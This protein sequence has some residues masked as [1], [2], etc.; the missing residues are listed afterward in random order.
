MSEDS[1]VEIV[2]APGCFDNF[3]GSQEELDEFVAELNRLAET[4]E[5]FEQS[6]PVDLDNLSEEDADLIEH[7]KITSDTPT[8]NLQ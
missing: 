8:R 1:K 3:E 6:R 2:F 4:G 5:L 7:L